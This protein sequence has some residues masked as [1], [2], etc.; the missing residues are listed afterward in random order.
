MM[1]RNSAAE[2]KPLP[3]LSNTL[4]ASKISS[5][6]SVSFILRAIMVKNS[7]KSIVPLP[8]ASTSLIM[9]WS[10]ASVGFWPKE[11]MTVPNSLVVM[12]PSPSLSNKENA[13]LNSAICSSVS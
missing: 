9:S 5:S 10:S 2:M 13:S 8:S 11:R 3:S 7:G 12:V 4:N 6:E 1:W